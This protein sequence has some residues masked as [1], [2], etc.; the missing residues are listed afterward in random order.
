[1]H[2][3]PFRAP[4]ALASKRTAVH[5]SYELQEQTQQYLEEA[6][7]RALLGDNAIR[8]TEAWATLL[9]SQ[10]PYSGLASTSVVP[11]QVHL[12]A[13]PATAQGGVSVAKLLQDRDSKYLAGDA[14]LILRDRRQAAATVET[15]GCAST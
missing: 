12:V 2:G 5:K 8:P 10:T 1:M 3:E 11:C 14:K 9:R 7:H 6:C 13:L 15:M 4:I